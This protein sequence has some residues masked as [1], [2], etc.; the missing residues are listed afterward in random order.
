MAE[1]KKISPGVVIV[2]GLILGTGAALGAVYLLA[3]AAPPPPP[4]GLANLYV[5]VID[6][7]HNP[8]RDALLTLDSLE[9][10]TNASGICNFL[11]LEPGPYS[12]HCSKS[13]Y[14]VVSVILNG[15]EIPFS[16]GN[17]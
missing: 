2:G 6:A 14:K 16:D 15:V 3:R 4:P 10:L 17:F 9:C 5:D 11:S 8:L 13:G 7:D 1:E 12:G